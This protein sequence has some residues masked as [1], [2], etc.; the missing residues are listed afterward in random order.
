M[1][2]NPTSIAAIDFERSLDA[3]RSKAARARRGSVWSEL[4]HLAGRPRGARLPPGRGA[5]SLL[6]LAHPWVATAIAEHSTALS[7]PIG[8]FHRTFETVFTLVFGSLEQALS[9]SRRLHRRHAAITGCLPER[10][11]LSSKGSPPMHRQRGLRADV[12]SRDTGGDR[13]HGPRSRA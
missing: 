6:Q 10:L 8:Q 13:A 1:S 11:G 2:A 12:G 5:L 3:V 9:T 4:D 7:D